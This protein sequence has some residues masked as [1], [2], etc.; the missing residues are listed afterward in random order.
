MGVSREITGWLVAGFFM[1]FFIPILNGCNQAI[2]QAKVAPD[3]QG[4][5]FAARRLIAQITIPLGMV[6]G[7]FLAD[8]VFEPLMTDPG[9]V[10]NAVFVPL[11]GSGPGAG[12]ALI[13]VFMGILGALVG[14]V[15]YL[16]P[17][18]RN[19]ED[20]LPDHDAV[21]GPSLDAAVQ[22]GA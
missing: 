15:G 14:V 3:V 20:L 5:V 18:V 16:V 21:E 22:A 19:A 11:V 2:W 10:A 12:M 13:M 6:V 4:R 17:A 1:A 9:P 8:N 7:G